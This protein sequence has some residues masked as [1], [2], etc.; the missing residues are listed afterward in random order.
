M[1]PRRDNK[2]RVIRKGG[3][4]EKV[5]KMAPCRAESR[6]PN[7]GPSGIVADG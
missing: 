3:G 5:K 4:D 7:K 2:I 6:L 1:N